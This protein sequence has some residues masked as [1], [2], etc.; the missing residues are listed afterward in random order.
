MIGKIMLV[1]MIINILIS[2]LFF[3]NIDKIWTTKHTN[4]N[5]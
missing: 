3:V 1:Y 4:K 5:K 2:V